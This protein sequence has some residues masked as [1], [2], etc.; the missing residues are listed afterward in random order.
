MKKLILNFILM[1]ALPVLLQAQY[2]GGNGRGEVSARLAN[3][4]LSV[5]DVTVES[6]SKCALAQNFPNPFN[7]A[8]TIKF[9]VAKSGDI[10]IVVL[11][12]MGCEVQTLVN[13][14][15]QPGIYETSFNGSLFSNGIY[16]YK[17]YSGEYSE[18]KRMTLVK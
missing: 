6:A 11:D 12:I 7:Q 14:T 5:H 9:K 4:V 17:I 10:K 8:T 2:S 1:L 16:I 15:L 13:K 18:T 3:V